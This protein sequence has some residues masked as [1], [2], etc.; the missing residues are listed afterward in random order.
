[1]AAPGAH[2]GFKTCGTRSITHTGVHDLN[3]GTLVDANML[4]KKLEVD[5]PRLKG[6]NLTVWA[7]TVGHQDGEVPHVGPHIKHH[8]ARLD[9]RFDGL[10][11]FRLVLAPNEP[12]PTADI[13]RFPLKWASLNLQG[14]ERQASF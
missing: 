11:F 2:T 10:G 1:M 6:N 9:H 12:D 5:I 14:D 7:N 3:V 8:I 4:S 13:P